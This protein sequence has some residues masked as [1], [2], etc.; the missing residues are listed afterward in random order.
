MLRS[1]RRRC[2]LVELPLL[3][4][5]NDR[6]AWLLLYPC[7]WSWRRAQHSDWNLSDVRS[8]STVV[9]LRRL[10]IQSVLVTLAPLMSVGS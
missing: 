1:S 9:V 4:L 5:V 3:V 6:V 7:C 2:E 10:A 8:Y